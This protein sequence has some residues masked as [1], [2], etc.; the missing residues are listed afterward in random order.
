MGGVNLKLEAIYSFTD[1]HVEGFFKEHRFLSNFHKAA[2]IDKDGRE[3]ATTE[4]YYQAKKSNDFQL[5]EEC[6]LLPL[7]EVKRWGR[8][9]EMRSD[10][11][12][13]VKDRVMLEALI[14]KFTQHDDL[15]EKLLATSERHLEETNWWKDTYWG[16][17]D[18]SG[19]NKLG[20]LLMGLR[21]D[22][23]MDMIL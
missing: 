5:Q 4:H 10:W 12:S 19:Q 7:G 20:L 22:I 18:G 16:V 2:F 23:R 11:E 15:K 9:V 17:Y 6:R 13:G 3:W 14:Y 1:D 8:N 21:N